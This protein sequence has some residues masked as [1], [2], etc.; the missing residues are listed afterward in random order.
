MTD[1]EKAA[2]LALEASQA[3]ARADAFFNSGPKPKTDL[4]RK[5]NFEAFQARKEIE[6]MGFYTWTDRRGR[7][8][9]FGPARRPQ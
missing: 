9:V 8:T 2:K 6:A 7:V 3:F 4:A 1:F 5:A